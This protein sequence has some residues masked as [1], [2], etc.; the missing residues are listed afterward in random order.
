MADVQGCQIDD[1]TKVRP[2]LTANGFLN[3]GLYELAIPEYQQFLKQSPNHE[4]ADLARYGLAVSLFR[5]ERWNEAAV[6]LDALRDDRG[7]EYAAEVQLL[8]GHCRL[9]SGD[10]SG[11]ATCFSNV[12]DHH[13]NHDLADDAAA[14][15][16]E[17][18][19]GRASCRERV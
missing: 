12:V 14:L 11:A 4:K 18:Q 6:E 15:L 3:R 9:S 7:F 8:S 17:S 16:V 19:I 13:R 1:E 2:Y 10:F 5:I